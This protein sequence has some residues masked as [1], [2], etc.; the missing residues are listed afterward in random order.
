MEKFGPR[1]SLDTDRS[2]EPPET[3]RPLS[4][5]GDPP[6]VAATDGWVKLSVNEA[7]SVCRIS[8]P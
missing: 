7:T 1:G 6:A 2:T 5:N 4:H 3:P 8:F